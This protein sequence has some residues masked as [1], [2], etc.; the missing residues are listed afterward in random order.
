MSAVAAV[1]SIVY[2][3]GSVFACCV[4]CYRSRTLGRRLDSLEDKLEKQKSIPL[5]YSVPVYSLP[6]GATAPTAPISIPSVS[7]PTRAV[8]EPVSPA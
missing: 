7:T 8:F 3:T 2:V 4:G 5:V 6:P 1:L